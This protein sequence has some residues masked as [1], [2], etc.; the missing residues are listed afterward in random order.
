MSTVAPR[1]AMPPAACRGPSRSPS[2]N[3]PS[4]TA[5]NA[6]IVITIAVRLAP[7][8]LSAAN[9][10]VNADAVATPLMSMSHHDGPGVRRPPVARPPT[11]KESDAPS[12]THAP[13]VSESVRGTARDDTSRYTEKLAAAA[14]A[15]TTPATE[16]STP[17]PATTMSTVPPTDSAS[18]PNNRG[19]G[20]NRRDASSSTATIAGYA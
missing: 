15:S 13:L 5:E 17:D 9:N 19:D 2:N 11:V 3:A 1:M 14:S 8:R 18:A 16:I 4:T 12:A 10:N 6:S 7:M 20:C